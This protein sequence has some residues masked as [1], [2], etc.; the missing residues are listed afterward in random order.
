MPARGFDIRPRL[1]L[2]RQRRRKRKLLRQKEAYVDS[3]RMY[4]YI[5]G[6]I[7]L[8]WVVP[9]VHCRQSRCSFL[10]LYREQQ[11]KR[12]FEVHYWTTVDKITSRPLCKQCEFRAEALRMKEQE[13]W[14]MQ[15]EEQI[16]PDTAKWR[17]L[18]RL[19]LTG[20]GCDDGNHPEG[21][22]F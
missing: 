21:Q 5:L 1:R 16:E 18:Q 12:G 11:W 6:S 4:R 7:R 19:L 8:D 14:M 17:V 10:E 22:I 15:Q 20:R 9:S 3:Y 2:W 13:G